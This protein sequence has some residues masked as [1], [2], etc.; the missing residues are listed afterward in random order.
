[1]SSVNKHLSL[2]IKQFIVEAFIKRWSVN[3]F[4]RYFSMTNCRGF[5]HTSTMSPGS[6]FWP[7]QIKKKRS[8]ISLNHNTKKQ[9][10]KCDKFDKKSY[11]LMFSYCCLL[12]EYI[13][14]FSYNP[15]SHL[16]ANRLCC[17]RQ[18]YEGGENRTKH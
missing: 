2:S 17:C 7:W 9:T 10:T 1:M 14:V 3:Y 18:M 5:I 11:F 6:P 13:V 4:R 16:C 12:S 8:D 15:L